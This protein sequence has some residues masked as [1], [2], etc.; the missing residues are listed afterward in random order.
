MSFF[1]LLERMRHKPL[2]TRRMVAASIAAC[3]VVVVIIVRLMAL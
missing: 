2:R 3:A 1:E